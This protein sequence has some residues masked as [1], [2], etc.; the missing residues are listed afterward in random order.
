MYVLPL[1][2]SGASPSDEDMVEERIPEIEEDDLVSKRN[3]PH[4]STHSLPASPLSYPPLP[5]PTLP[6]PTLP[7]PLLSSPLS[8]EVDLTHGRLKA[9]PDVILTL[10]K[11]E[12]LTLRQNLIPDM[13]PLSGLRTL[14]ELDLYDNELSTIAGLEE[15]S[16]LT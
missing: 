5:S 13:E 7:S 1:T 8:Q 10:K 14:R 9:I 6:S 3:N 4:T 11:V 16:S 15:M 12:V 2:A